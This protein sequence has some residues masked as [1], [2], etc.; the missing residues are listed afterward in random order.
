MTEEAFS[1]SKPVVIMLSR[2]RIP[3]S[4]MNCT[5]RGQRLLS[6]SFF[7][8]RKLDIHF[9]R[10][11]SP[12]LENLGSEPLYAD[13]MIGVLTVFSILHTFH[14]LPCQFH[15]HLNDWNF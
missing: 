4:H 8:K 14:I 10:L 3:S 6:T 1:T 2:P 9:C 11:I 7:Q 5:L 13:P 15:Q 12:N